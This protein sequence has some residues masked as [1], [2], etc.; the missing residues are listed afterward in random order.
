MN[1]FIY[2]YKSKTGRFDSKSRDRK[3]KGI[4]GI[5]IDHLI[6]EVPQDCYN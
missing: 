4:S 2:H 3:S 6:K 5:G 1:K